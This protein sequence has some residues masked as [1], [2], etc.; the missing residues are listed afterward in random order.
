MNAHGACRSCSA[1]VWWGINE[2]GGRGNPLDP[3]PVPDGNIIIVR[4]EAD[5]RPLI[6]YLKK[7][8]EVET[9]VDRYVSHFST[10]PDAEDWRK[11]NEARRKSESYQQLEATS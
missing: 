2:R 5:G 3:E 4:I 9:G 6:R 10:C 1:D 7:D 8:E 11:K